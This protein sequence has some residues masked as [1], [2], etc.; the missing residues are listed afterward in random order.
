MDAGAEKGPD[1]AEIACT[2]AVR[3]CSPGL[4]NARGSS[5]SLGA[6]DDSIGSVSLSQCSRIAMGAC[7]QASADE[8]PC[9]R[10]LAHGSGACDARDFATVLQGQAAGICEAWA[11]SITGVDPAS[12]QWA[13]QQGQQ[14]VQEAGG[15][16][17]LLRR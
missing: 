10:E 9:R 5:D 6:S 14:Q 3:A 13:Q 11:S 7:Q 4:W 2:V 1:I 16:R 15:Y 8:A 17:R 12:G